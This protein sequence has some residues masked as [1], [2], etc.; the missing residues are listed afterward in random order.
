MSQILPNEIILHIISFLDPKIDF[1]IL[2]KLR[3][4]CQT[5][6][7]FVDY[8]FLLRDFNKLIEIHLSG[9]RYFSSKLLKK[10]ATIIWQPISNEISIIVDRSFDEFYF[11]FHQL[12]HLLIKDHYSLLSLMKGANVENGISFHQFDNVVKKIFYHNVNT[13]KML[14]LVK[15]S[16][17]TQNLNDSDRYW[18]Y[19][20]K[21]AEIRYTFSKNF[22]IATDELSSMTS[23]E[24][25]PFLFS[26][27]TNQS[28]SSLIKYNQGSRKYSDNNRYNLNYFHFIDSPYHIDFDLCVHRF[29]R[30]YDPYGVNHISRLFRFLKIKQQSQII[31]YLSISDFLV[32]IF[33][34]FFDIEALPQCTLNIVQFLTNPIE[35]SY[36]QSKLLKLKSISRIPKLQQ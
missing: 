29:N 15:E 13:G 22:S 26:E 28:K 16:F 9:R 35:L 32:Q 23:G 6:R 30:T 31:P 18:W 27:E 4:V 2:L 1:E 7:Y 19:F 11:D 20:T 3:K 8:D 24:F 14:K 17:Q 10:A 25:Y 33:A 5:F 12:E 21:R 34:S 36:P